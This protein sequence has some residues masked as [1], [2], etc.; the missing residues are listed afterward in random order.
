MNIKSNKLIFKSYLTILTLAFVIAGCAGSRSQLKVGEVEGGKVVE[1]EGLA[2]YKADDMVATKRASLVDAQRNA[3]EKVV[4]VYISAKTLVEKAV[5]I[6]NTILAKTEGYIKKFDI[7]KEGVD[8]D[9][10]KTK[11]RALVALGDLARDLEEMDLLRT[12]EIE[13]PRIHINIV[14]QVDRDYVDDKPA[15]RSLEE[16]LLGQGF[17]IVSEGGSKEADLVMEGK[18]SSFPFQ[19]TGLGGFVSYRAR[20]TLQVRRPGT[21]DI[22]YSTQKEAS[23]LG[24]NKELAGL[25]ALETVGKLA[26][27]EIGDPLF[28]EWAKGKNLLVM[29]EGV[30]SFDKVDRI[31]KHLEAQPGIEDLVLRFYQEEMAQFELRLD[32]LKPDELASRLEKSKTIKLKV[33]ETTP[34]SLRLRVK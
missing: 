34:Q 16:S 14:E 26:G 19:A 10:Y 1:A 7:L 8:K 33:I 22:I 5:A 31:K 6:E 17:K 9:L 18:G 2:P 12:P 28:Q 13:R 15:S 3:I 30:D 20:L 21:K 4:G 29:V 32:N 11:I 27:D 24:G 25:K 23:G